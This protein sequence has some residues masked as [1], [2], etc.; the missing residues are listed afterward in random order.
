MLVCLARRLRGALEHGPAVT[1]LIALAGLSVPF[2]LV[3]GG[4][5][6]GAALGPGLDA[7]AARGL[8]TGLGLAAAAAGA[9]VALAAPGAAGLGPQL[10]A[11]P[12]RRR[13]VVLALTFLPAALGAAP[14]A[15]ALVALTVPFA[16]ATP[17][18]AVAALPLVLAV[19]AAA[20]AGAATAESLLAAARGNAAGALGIATAA[21]V[22]LATGG[23]AL[24]P[25]DA[26]ARSLAG[27]RSAV[28]SGGAAAL[29]LLALSCEWLVLAARRPAE[30]PVSSPRVL[31]R[32]PRRPLPAVMALSLKRLLRRRELRRSVGAT[33]ILAAAGAGIASTGGS[34]PAASA[35]LAAGTASLG[36][37]L[38]PL[39]EPGLARQ[40]RW[41]VATAPVSRE[42]AAAAGGAVA[43]ALAIAATLVVSAP[44]AIAVPAELPKLALLALV[45][46]C[47]ALAAGS[48]VPWRGERL[49]DQFASFAA[50]AGALTAVSVLGGV[51]GRAVD[52]GLPDLAAAVS[53]SLVC[54]AA[55][56]GAAALAG[57]GR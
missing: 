16:A 18:G 14:A 31:M 41:L 30:R 15:A 44:F 32:V 36:A 54:V 7:D 1:V 52:L 40:A 33:L 11:A 12:L 39:A 50:F 3:L 45:T 9:A 19:A 42:G 20:A 49:A 43:A 4:R 29:V 46:A 55:G 8:V 53:L 27:S 57:R 28:A 47:A 35:V 24:G 56:L 17:G 26:A 38:L 48:L 51:A 34:P 25:L 37:S 23:V 13:D 6:L 22:W 5:S 21:A 2:A 10:R